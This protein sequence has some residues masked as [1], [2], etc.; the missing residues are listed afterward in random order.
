MGGWEQH[1]FQVEKSFP[2]SPQET[3]LTA[4]WPELSRM[5]PLALW[6]VRR[7]NML[8]DINGREGYC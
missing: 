6:E 7:M 5:P 2:K 3:S 1:A 8:L 4:Y